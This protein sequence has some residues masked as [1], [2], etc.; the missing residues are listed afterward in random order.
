M[1]TLSIQYLFRKKG[2]F[3]VLVRDLALKKSI[4]LSKIHLSE[5]AR[6]LHVIVKDD[7]GLIPS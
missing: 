5:M 2:V 7:G 6:F 3:S 4:L 1:Y